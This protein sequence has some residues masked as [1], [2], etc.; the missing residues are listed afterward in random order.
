A[1]D[2]S[3]YKI[4]SAYNLMH[5]LGN[6]AWQNMYSN[7]LKFAFRPTDG[8]LYTLT[9]DS[10]LSVN[11]SHTWLNTEDFA[12]A[13][14]GSLWVLDQSTNLSHRTNAGVW[15]LYTSNV[16]AFGF[17]NNSLTPTTNAAVATD[18]TNSGVLDVFGSVVTD[19]IRIAPNYQV[20]GW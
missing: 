14:D 5:Y 16:A 18:P 13:G 17:T 15:Q 1:P 12:F 6:G 2:G 20:S 19:N 7:V 10:W 11:Y 4:D 3:I 8:S 9:S